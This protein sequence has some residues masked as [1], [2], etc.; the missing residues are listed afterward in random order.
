MT[1]LCIEMDCNIIPSFN[2]SNEKGTIYCNKHKKENM[3]NTHNKRCIEPDCIKQPIYN[4]SNEKGA[5]YCNKHKKENMVNVI[6]KRCIEPNCNTRPAFNYPDKKIAIY[7]NN[8]KK[9]N[10]IDVVSKRCIETDCDKRPTFNYTNKKGAIYCFAHRKENMIDI[11]HK[12][13]IEPYCDIIP[14]FNYKDEKS[15]IYCSIHKKENM[16]DIIH[17]RCIEENCD[18]YPLPKYNHC[19]T[20]FRFKFPYHKRWTNIKQKEIF[21]VNEIINYLPNLDWIT[22]KI[23]SCQTCSRRRPDLFIDLYNYSLIIEIDENQHKNYDTTCDNKRTMEIFT[24]LGNR[25]IIFIRFN[26]DNYDKQKGI[27]S[28]SKSGLISTNENYTDRINKLKECI[29]FHLSI[30]P[31]KEITIEYL[32]FN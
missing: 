31:T 15:A 14:T 27:F 10:M 26:P 19:S 32:F 12:R 25:P 3:I 4:F 5:I 24:A 23:I 8:H 22:D 30:A 28:F 7:C 2:F 16:I 21:I 20:C 29:D 17:K 11:I 6:S 9:K 1:K 13:C 18:K